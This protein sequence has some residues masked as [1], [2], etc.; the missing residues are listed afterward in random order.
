MKTEKVWT[1][2]SGS[3]SD[4]HIV[5]IF[6]SRKNAKTVLAVLKDKD[7]EARIVE[8]NLDP[9]VDGI[10]RGLKIF[11]VHMLRNGDVESVDL[12]EID[13]YDLAGEVSIWRRSTA[14]FYRG[15]GVP[16]VMTASIWAEDKT[17]AIKAANEKRTQFIASGEW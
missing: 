15:K 12:H 14:P 10:R 6:S 7:P 11:R 16:D 13:R 4:Y 17:Q 1:I 3:Y 8:H 2:E 5:G 9:A